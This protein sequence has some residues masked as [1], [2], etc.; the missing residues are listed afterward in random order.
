MPTSPTAQAHERARHPT[1]TTTAHFAALDGLRGLAI[2][3]V[4]AFHVA[5]IASDNAPWAY[6]SSPPWYSWPV[7]A[8]SL[9]VDIFF[10]LSGFLVLRSWRSIRETYRDD[11]FRSAAEFARRRGRR[12]LP[13]YWA[14]LLI[15]IPWRTPEWLS[16]AGGWSNIAM[17]ASLNQSVDPGLPQQLNTVTWSLTTETHFYVVLPVL[18]MVGARYGWG[19]LLSLLIVATVGWRLVV[20]G[21]GEQ[22]EWILGRADQFVAG[23]LAYTL[24]EKHGTGVPSTLGRWLTGSRA[25]WILGTSLAV[26][27]LTHGALRLVQKPLIFL[28]LLHAAT[29]LA[30]AGLLVRGLCRDGMRL[31]RSP[32]VG[33]MLGWLGLISYSLYLWHWPIVAEASRMW[34][35]SA[36]VLALACV[37]SVAVGVL[38]YA[39]LERPFLRTSA[40][41]PK[42]ETPD[43]LRE[44][45]RT[46]ATMAKSRWSGSSSVELAP[47]GNST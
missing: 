3:A 17:F 33:R 36:G 6:H 35:T 7:F 18:A 37:V 31:F 25:G 44:E 40:S 32:I 21:T 15:L 19:R 47:L 24:V 4:V 11:G 16:S 38:S 8:G 14:A 45:T 20:G 43:Q 42:D 46:E 39:L 34:G 2:L 12:L 9:G 27:A 23:M 30:V 13:P 41:S 5:V 28:S 26:V 10:V 1:P 29:G 22:A